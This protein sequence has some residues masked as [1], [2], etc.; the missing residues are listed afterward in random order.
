[1]AEK[2]A[3][4][5]QDNTAKDDNPAAMRPPRLAVSINQLDIQ[6]E[7]ATSD[8]GNTARA[9]EITLEVVKE[10]VDWICAMLE[11][12]EMW[13]KAWSTIGG[14]H[15]TKEWNN[16]EEESW[17]KLMDELFLGCAYSGSEI[18]AG[19]PS[20]GTVKGATQYIY[21]RFMADIEDVYE[22]KP[23]TDPAYSIA[24]ACQHLTTYGAVGRG[25]RVD[26]DMGGGCIPASQ[27]GAALPIF[28][29]GSGKWY[30]TKP[31]QILGVDAK[32]DI[33][34]YGR[35]TT[36]TAFN[37]NAVTYTVPGYGPGTV[38]AYNP[39]GH[40]EFTFVEVGEDELVK[41]DG[42]IKK[43]D[44]G[45]AYVLPRAAL[46]KELEAQNA[47]RA[48]DS[49]LAAV[50]SIAKNT[51]KMDVGKRE[52]LP[53]DQALAMTLKSD[54]TIPEEEKNKAG[55]YTALLRHSAQLDG[56][57]VSMVLRTYKMGADNVVQLLDTTSHT[58]GNM[59][60]YPMFRPVA[61]YSG[62]F[63]GEHFTK[64]E[65]NQ[66]NFVG[67]GV[68]P[69]LTSA[70][71][72]QLDA[73]RRARPVGLARLVVARA[74][75]ATA[76]FGEDDILFVSRMIPMW[77]RADPKRNYS[78]ARLLLSLR[79]TPYYASLQAFWVVYAPRGALAEVMWGETARGMTLEAMQT[80]TVKRANAYAD[81]KKPALPDGARESRKHER[82]RL[83][84]AL[85]LLPIAVVATKEGGLAQQVWR[86]HL[87]PV[88]QGTPPK[89][90]RELFIATGCPSVDFL[91]KKQKE[92]TKLFEADRDKRGKRAIE[93]NKE[94]GRASKAGDTARI[95]NLKAELVELYKTPL[96]GVEDLWEMGDD[97]FANKFV[98]KLTP[99][100]ENPFA[101]FTHEALAQP[102]SFELPP[103]LR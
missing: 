71:E 11:D 77:S 40:T 50:D 66:N 64:I 47:K 41:E 45:N 14:K 88:G 58:T 95:A 80:E 46:S 23:N 73:M 35:I 103:M 86:N 70:A 83:S 5:D 29:Q 93:I 85:D 9:D 53:I 89:I 63:A 8:F 74:A 78:I 3:G 55:R 76:D 26:A 90:I 100:R 22:N 84:T 60:D 20:K 27:R 59:G 13:G 69:A 67:I 65:G 2:T 31:I 96:E 98:S 12:D 18:V 28:R 39:M 42:K 15:P 94:A 21:S 91:L 33:E 51:F 81:P 82:T 36:F 72:G 57:H 75:S 68:L 1:M 52:I 34:M 38:Y 48:T 101:C 37:A 61:Q 99:Y 7:R 17:A 79:N 32:L 24:V 4:T 97:P 87:A 10:V 43:D 19:F 44:D 62:I 102:A 49:T 6:P 30:T 25:I 54:P 56:S 92:L 16:D